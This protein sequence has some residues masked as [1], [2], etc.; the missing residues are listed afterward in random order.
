MIY[1]KAQDRTDYFCFSFSL[2]T[3]RSKTPAHFMRRWVNSTVI[4]SK[5]PPRIRDT[6]PFLQILKWEIETQNDARKFVSPVIFNQSLNLQVL[7]LHLLTYLLHQLGVCFYYGTSPGI[8]EK[9][10]LLWN[11]NENVADNTPNSQVSNSLP[12]IITQK[13]FKKGVLNC[14]PNF[15]Q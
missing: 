9:R 5:N 1:S 8:S 2:E 7:G 4:S 14:G 11:C 15:Y 13:D 12:Y 3:K 10:R 6:H